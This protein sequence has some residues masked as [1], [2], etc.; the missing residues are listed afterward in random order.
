MGHP[1]IGHT[2]FC[3]RADKC[4]SHWIVPEIVRLVA[5][6]PAAVV[7]SVFPVPRLNRFLGEKIVNPDLSLHLGLAFSPLWAKSITCNF[8]LEVCYF[9][10][11]RILYDFILCHAVAH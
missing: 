6:A 1:L 9:D 2:Q 5:A 10:F 11:G 7:N 3:Q 4:L 8:L